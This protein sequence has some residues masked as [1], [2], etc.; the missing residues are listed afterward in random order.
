MADIYDNLTAPDNTGNISPWYDQN[1]ISSTYPQKWSQFFVDTSKIVNINP[2]YFSTTLIA[3]TSYTIS[4]TERV[5]MYGCLLAM[6]RITNHGE[7]IL[8]FLVTATQDQEYK[9]DDLYNFVYMISGNQTP[10]T[11]NPQTAPQPI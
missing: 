6:A 8:D 11:N 1:Y 10:I 7:S 2:S 4:E 5:L 9:F 3:N